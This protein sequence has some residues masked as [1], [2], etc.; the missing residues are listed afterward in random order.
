MKERP[1]F[2][3]VAF[4]ILFLVG[5]GAIHGDEPSSGPHAWKDV[6]GAIEWE[7]NRY[8]L[9]PEIWSTRMAW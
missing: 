5:V 9:Y 8:N 6:T 2:L 1:L 3:T 7:E 4:G